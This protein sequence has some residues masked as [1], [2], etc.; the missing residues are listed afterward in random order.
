METMPT[1]LFI[2]DNVDLVVVGREERTPLLRARVGP[3]VVVV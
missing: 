2:P 3:P 1:R